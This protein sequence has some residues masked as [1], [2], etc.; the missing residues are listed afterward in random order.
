MIGARHLNEQLMEKLT[1]IRSPGVHLASSTDSTR[2]TSLGTK[3]GSAR[4]GTHSEQARTDYP[5]LLLHLPL[6]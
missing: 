3:A 4:R 2:R 1:C 5:R 6:R